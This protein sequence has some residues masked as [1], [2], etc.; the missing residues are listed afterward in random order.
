MLKKKI[1]PPRQILIA[2]EWEG[3][4]KFLSYLCDLYYPRWQNFRIKS[5]NIHGKSPD[6]IVNTVLREWH[7][8]RFAW[9]D[10]DR[11]EINKAR[12]IAKKNWIV[13]FENKPLEFEWEILRMLGR[14]IKQISDYK[15]KFEELYPDKD[16]LDKKT[17]AEFF[18]K[19]KLE[20]LRQDESFI[21]GKIIK[22]LET[23]EL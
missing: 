10:T 7:K 23:G 2:C 5:K 3:E 19:E 14:E 22:L 4:I 12:I 8:Y 18:S 9:L 1:C 13:L 20:S 15:R 21:I 11:P 6:V 17:Y 16:L